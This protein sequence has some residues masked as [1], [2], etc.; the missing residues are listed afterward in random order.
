MAVFEFAWWVGVSAGR[1]RARNGVMPADS[2]VS[3]GGVATA[4]AG[5]ARPGYFVWTAGRLV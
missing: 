2:T 1:F 4:A 5:H 3:G